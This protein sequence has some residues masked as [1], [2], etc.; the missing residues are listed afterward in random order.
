MYG[1][2][3][4]KTYIE[5]HTHAKKIYILKENFMHFFS[6]RTEGNS[7]RV[8]WYSVLPFLPD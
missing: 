3:N 8:C 6:Q 2:I 1:I 5:T 4:V 7:A